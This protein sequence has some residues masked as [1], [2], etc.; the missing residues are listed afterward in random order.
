MTVFCFKILG[1]IPQH[2]NDLISAF[3]LEPFY[4]SHASVTSFPSV[5]Y[6]GIDKIV[7]LV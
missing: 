2:L 6:K 3:N 4:P 5:T 7:I 1:S